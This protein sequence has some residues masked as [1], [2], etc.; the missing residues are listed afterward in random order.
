M[1]A[2]SCLE[3]RP[4]EN[5]AVSH[6]LWEGIAMS[7]TRSAVLCSIAGLL[8][9]VVTAGPATADRYIETDPAGDMWARHYSGPDSSYQYATAPEHENLDI[10]R[11]VVRHAP[12]VVFI[13]VA[14]R[15]LT[16][17]RDG[18]SFGLNGFI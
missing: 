16:R 18:Q 4:A 2:R 10:R 17:L 9:A 13:R 15:E 3:R 12:R 14:M 5:P 1:V 6:V 8:S 7:L 11:V